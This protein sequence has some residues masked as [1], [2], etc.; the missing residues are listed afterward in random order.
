ME[1]Y[2]IYQFKD[3]QNVDLIVDALYEGGTY[4]NAGDDPISKLVG[5]GNQGG[6]RYVGSLDAGIR[7]CVLYSSLSDMDW[8][9]SLD[10]E[11]GQFVYY[12]DNKSPGHDLHN[13]W[14]KGNEVLRNVFNDLHSGGRLEIP[15][16][17]V[18]TKG[19]K[20]RDVF[21]R[22]IA[23]PGAIGLG[24]REDLVAIWKTKNGQRFQNYR[25]TFTILNAPVIDRRWI[26][27]FQE[28]AA[29]LENAPSAWNRWI[30]TGD[31]DPL[32]A[33]RTERHR[34]R[35]EQIPR[36]G[37]RREILEK[38]IG[39]FKNHDNKEYAFEKCAA[40][41]ARMMD[42]NI[43]ACDLTRPWRDGGRDAIGKYRIGTGNCAIDVEFALEAKCHEIRVGSGVRETSRLI[44]RLRYRQFG[45]FITT[46]YVSEQAYKEI[47]EDNHPVIILGGGDITDIL[48]NAGLSNLDIVSN[49]LMNNF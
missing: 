43:V 41:I 33:P 15:P 14:R 25:A 20:G 24:S 23:V 44:S 28:E 39:Y 47:I 9:D 10:L 8:P 49:W 42:S 35:E 32:V 30:T 34:K 2:R 17:F 31:Y 13:T 27:E 19:P 22:G 45:I 6:F 16:F 21:F 7:L 40:E 18:F 36:Q 26:N 4:G 1:D 5:C 3:L 48:I 11:T 37:V 38:I 46:S 12:G 29:P